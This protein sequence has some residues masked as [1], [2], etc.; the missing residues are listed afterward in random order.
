MRRERTMNRL[1]SIAVLALLHFGSPAAMASAESAPAAGVS[2]ESVSAESTPGPIV[3]TD[4]PVTST[5][6][7]YVYDPSGNVAAVGN[8][9]YVYDPMGRVTTGSVDRFGNVQSQTY[10]YDVYGNRLGDGTVSYPASTQ[11]NR[12]TG[13]G[14][15][16]DAAGNLTQWQPPGSATART[17]SYD[18]LS[19]NMREKVTVSGTDKYVVHIYTADDERYWEYKDYGGGTTEMR[20]ALRDLGGT[21][22]REFVETAIN[23]SAAAWTAHDYV[24]RDSALLA[25]YDTA[26]GDTYHYSLDQLGTPRIVTDQDHVKVAEHTYF[27]FGAEYTDG[28]STD[29]RLHFTGHEERD[30]DFLLE[31]RGELDY[32]HARYYSAGMGRFLSV[33][34]VTGEV[35]RPLSWNRYAYVRNSPLNLTDPSGMNPCPVIECPQPVPSYSDDL[36]AALEWANHKQQLVRDA[37]D[38]AAARRYYR[39][40]SDAASLEGNDLEAALYDGLLDQLPETQNELTIDLAMTVIPFGKLAKPGAKI[41]GVITGFTKH[42]INRAIQRGVK[43]SQILNAVLKP[44]KPVISKIDKLGRKSIK[45]VGTEATVVVNPQGKVVTVYK[46]TR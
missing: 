8:N 23:G 16:Y 42:G 17:Y 38:V 46:T 33:D 10:T 21:V 44:I 1:S 19:T 36:L 24:Y 5:T 31:P 34:P 18:A 11:T 15:Q 43:P 7:T 14:A 39:E 26:T 9:S 35:T 37:F 3:P 40:R 29:G 32:M 27:P 25:A 20:Y 41:G 12:L 45:Y 2:A 6:G 13:S 30:A 4:G 28:S 22:L